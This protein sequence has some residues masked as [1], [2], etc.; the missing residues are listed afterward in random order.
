M[1]LRQPDREFCSVFAFC[2]VLGSWYFLIVFVIENTRWNLLKCFAD[3]ELCTADSFTELME[4]NHDDEVVDIERFDM[5]MEEVTLD[6][7]Q[8][9]QQEVA[10]RL[11]TPI[12]NTFLDTKDIAFERYA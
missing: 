2:F 3:C 9:N 12:V 5:E 10:K 11:T 1:P 7:M 6:S 4:I 8:P